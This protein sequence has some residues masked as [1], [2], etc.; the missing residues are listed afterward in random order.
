VTVLFA[1]LKGSMELLADRD[2]EEARG[3]LDPV[4]ERMME[5]V[6]RYEGTVNQVMGDGI[7]AL[8]GAPLA[9]EDHAARACYAALRMQESVTRYGDEVQRAHGVP[10]QIRVGVNS[11]EVVVR[12]IG[13]DLRM[14]YS[15][16]GQT[17]HLA[18]RMEQMAKPGSILLTT[19][20]MRL[21]EG[22]VRVTPLGPV[23]VKG[24]DQPIEV[25]ELTGASSGRTRL[26][27]RAAAGLTPFVGREQEIDQLRDAL[28]RARNGQGQIVAV[29]G[30]PGVGKSRLAWELTHS[31]RAHGW[32]VL[33]ASSVSYG[34]ATPYLPVLGVLKMYFAV[35]DR[36]DP[37][38]VREKVMGKVLALDD[39]LRPDLP[40]FLALMDAPD[41]TAEWRRLDAAEQ[42]RRTREAM[43]R[44]FLRE[45]QAQPLL[46]VFE[47]L[48]WID[49]DTQAF[50]DAFVESL[51]SARVLLLVNFRQEYRHQWAS[52]SSYTQI[53]LDPLPVETAEAL[54]ASL[55]G[56]DPALEEIRSSLI[57]RTHGNPFFLEECVHDL[58]ETGVLA[59]DRGALRLTRAAEHI[60]VPATVQ[61]ILAARI[62][63]IPPDDKQVLQTAAVIGKD[64]PLAVLQTIAE[65]PED[66]LRPALS[67]LQAAELIHETRLFP[68]VEYTFKHSLTHEVAYGG[69]LVERRRALHARILDALERLYPDHVADQAD[70]LAHHAFRGEVWSKALSYLRRAGVRED[71]WTPGTVMG[72]PESPGHLW[73]TGEH[74][75]AFRAAQRDLAVAAG[76]GNFAMRV[77]ATCRLGQI[78]HALGDYPRAAD[79]LRGVVASLEGDLANE[80]FGMAARP[81]V[82]ARVWLSRC[83]AEQGHFAEARAATEAALSMAEAAGHPYTLMH[84]LWGLG[85]LEFLA[86]DVPRAIAMLE[87]GL[88]IERV[89][90]IPLLYPFVAVPLGAAYVMD[91]RVDEG[92]ALMEQAV[93][94]A[95]AARLVAGHAVRLA[96]LGHGHRVA[97]QLDTAAALAARALDLARIHGER[98]SAAYALRLA[99]DVAAAQHPQSV[100]SAEASYREA[101]AITDALGMR[102]LGA[103]CHLGLGRLHRHAGDRERARGHLSVAVGLFGRLGMSWWQGQAAA[104]MAGLGTA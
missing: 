73:W 26:Q 34:R 74:E 50:L 28:A 68:E 59:G 7:M 98:G 84:A 25:F 75:R 38:R 62:D 19:N 89:S 83:L 94:Q 63:R 70:R 48:H 37:R 35:E 46:L 77:V 101:L 43:R 51:A 78:H 18:A 2:P 69:L 85:A 54:L 55:V 71:E 80:H 39:S 86:G 30:E 56:T 66:T 40:A 92:L 12:S 64:V 15:A 104:E 10:L 22:Y 88:V 49:A 13:S 52:K 82:F 45:S 33:E 96:W 60:H 57:Q 53:R 91:G 97:G 4:L 31:H 11:G 14:D 5:A 23:S 27:V 87:R 103:Q 100:E 65:L 24:L 3:L 8:F 9:H 47:D 21:V 72:G 99:G 81:A 17:T 90:G 41:A 16:V 20:A 6:H 67:R 42:G 44:L 79:L 36:D 93:D 1:D 32:L 29:V 58:R 76:F 102:P 61:A 95:A